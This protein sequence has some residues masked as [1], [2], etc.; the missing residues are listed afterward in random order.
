MGLAFRVRFTDEEIDS[1]GELGA[2][3]RRM[4]AANEP[5]ARREPQR[6][7]LL[8]GHIEPCDPTTEDA[9]LR[10]FVEGMAALA[11][12]LSLEGALHLPSI[13]ATN[14]SGRIVA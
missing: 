3:W 9:A 12:R 10:R 4:I 1:L 13:P 6:A 7:R 14:E 5:G 8:R 2:F 11:T